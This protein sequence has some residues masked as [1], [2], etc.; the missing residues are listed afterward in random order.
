[1]RQ[2]ILSFFLLFIS[3]NFAQN[4]VTYKIDENFSI[5]MPQNL[6]ISDTLQQKVIKG[7]LDNSIVII[8]KNIQKDTIV[9]IESVE[10][11]MKYY[12][13]AQEGIL[14]SSK[15]KLLRKK[16]ISIQGLK[17]LNFSTETS[18]SGEQKL[19]DN[20]LLFLNNYTYVLVFIHSADN[21]EKFNIQKEKIISSFKFRKG[22]SIKNQFNNYE[23]SSRAFLWGELT[24]KVI[25]YLII[26]GAIVFLIYKNRKEKHIA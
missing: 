4:L 19:W 8:T 20:Y 5:A 24:G 15:G 6:E 2:I 12:D 13:G 21:A 18:I 7:F 3:S 22:L 10:D 23:S 1:M 17:F 25:F 16:I 26:F 14:N 9:T 11:L